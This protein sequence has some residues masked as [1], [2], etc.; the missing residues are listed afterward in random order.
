VI[1]LSDQNWRIAGVGDFNGDGKADILWRNSSTG[2]I[3]IWSMNGTQKL[4]DVLVTNLP[5]QNWRI[6]GTGDFNGD[7]KAD[8]LWRN[9][10]TGDIRIW[11][12]NG[13]QITAD[14]FVTS[15]ADLNWRVATLTTTSS[16]AGATILYEA[17]PPASTS[18]GF[19]TL[20]NTE[21]AKGYRYFGDIYFNGPMSSIFVKDNSKS[22]IFSYEALPPASTSSDIITLVNTEGAK[23]YRY[24][25]NISISGSVSTILTKDNS[26]NSTF[27]Y[28]ALPPA[29]SASG[30]L[31]QSTAAG[32]TGYSYLGDYYFSGSISS[33]Y[34]N[35]S[36]CSGSL[37]SLISNVLTF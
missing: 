24:L 5:D 22:T 32:A 20:V 1:N 36:Q 37:C 29:S 23:G 30:F 13:Q 7:G 31:T 6:V 9:S 19:I 2:D 3:R 17:W 10:S 26:Q 35:L 14:V 18:S 27:I 28:E 33:I 11:Y 12:T 15:L 34:I 25:G 8:I 4:S 21:G 16:Y